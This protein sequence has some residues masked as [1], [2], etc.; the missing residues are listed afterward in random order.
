MTTL[1]DATACGQLVKRLAT[2]PANAPRQWGKMDVAQMFA[3][4]A[5]A[6]E[7]AAGEHPAKQKLIGKLLAWTLR[8]RA[9]GLV[10]FDRNMPTD[11]SFIMAGVHDVSKERSRLDAAVRRYAQAGPDAA[12]K[13]QH[14]FFGSL[15]GDEWG[16]LMWKHLD[17]HFRQFGG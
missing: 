8:K 13:H 7:T 2:L 3:H 12:A 14:L 16:V 9:L 4:C 17:H 5:H 15:T 10:P 1:F 11:K 6:L